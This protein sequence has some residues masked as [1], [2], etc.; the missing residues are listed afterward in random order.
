[1]Y[2]KMCSVLFCYLAPPAPPKTRAGSNPQRG[3]PGALAR[4]GH[5]ALLLTAH[6]PELVREPASEVGNVRGH[7][8]ELTSTTAYAHHPVF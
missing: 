8:E 4:K 5:T 7:M 6:W 2:F 3:G 1:M